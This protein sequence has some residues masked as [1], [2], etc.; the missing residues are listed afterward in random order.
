MLRSKELINTSSKSY[1]K[2]TYLCIMDFEVSSPFINWYRST[3]EFIVDRISY[4]LVTRS[5]DSYNQFISYKYLCIVNFC[6]QK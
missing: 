5:F 3:I 4:Q 2:N 1:D 6:F